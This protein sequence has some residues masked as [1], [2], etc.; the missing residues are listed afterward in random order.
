MS[1]VVLFEIVFNFSREDSTEKVL[2]FYWI[3]DLQTTIMY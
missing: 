3:V 2:Q 1:F